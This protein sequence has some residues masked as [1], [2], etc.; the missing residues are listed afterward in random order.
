MP[1][2]NKSE[3][4]L[5][6]FVCHRFI[7]C[8]IKKF[9]LG[10]NDSSVALWDLSKLEELPDGQHVSY[11][12][13]HTSP[14]HNRNLDVTEACKVS[15]VQHESKI[16]WL[17]PVCINNENIIADQTLELALPPFA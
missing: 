15:K 5:C 7:L 11:R 8:R 2:E 14:I 1:V 3:I 9:I 16:N 6:V 10:G 17:K 12:N 4:F 13:G